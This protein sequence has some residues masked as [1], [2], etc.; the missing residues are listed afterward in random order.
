MRFSTSSSVL[1]IALAASFSVPNAEASLVT[2][3]DFETGDFTGWT[4]FTTINGSLGSTSIVSYDTNN[5]SV[6]SRSARFQVGQVNVGV[7]HQGGGIYQ[8][9]TTSGGSLSISADIAMENL[10]VGTNVAGG[11]FEL[12]F[13]GVVVDS[14]DF[15]QAVA[16]T[17][18]YSLLATVTG[19]SA[20]THEIAIRMTRPYLPSGV[21]QYIDNVVAIESGA[22]AVPEAS[23]ILAW[24]MVLGGVGLMAYRHQFCD[25]PAV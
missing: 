2:N 11:L 12:L 21:H 20:G 5:D 15:G 22:M 17:P 4:T 13:D 3:G 6:A 16:G 14:F 23:S 18:E 1:L 10:G 8:S 7:T 24:T 19:A 9:I 25:K